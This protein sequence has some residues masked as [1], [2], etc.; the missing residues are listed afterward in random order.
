MAFDLGSHLIDQVL[1]LFGLPDRVTAI[2]RDEGSSSPRSCSERGFIDDGFLIIFYHDKQNIMG[3]LGSDL[4]VGMNERLTHDWEL[5]ELH[6]T[7]FSVLSSQERFEVLGDRGSWVKYGLDCQEEVSEQYQIWTC[8]ILFSQDIGRVMR[9][10]RSLEC[11]MLG[12]NTGKISAA[13]THFGGVQ[14]SGYGREGSK[15]GMAEYETV[16]AVTIGNIDA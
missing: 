15:Y 6:A 1:V 16:K 13:E 11:G 7:Q 3:Q 10:A 12:A 14:E 4:I 2:L 5:V 8:R 9:T